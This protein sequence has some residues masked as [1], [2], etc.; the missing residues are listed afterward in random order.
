MWP[1]SD[2]LGFNGGRK[3]KRVK[4]K[5]EFFSETNFRALFN[6]WMKVLLSFF[7]RRVRIFQLKKEAA[8][9]LFAFSPVTTHTHKK[10]PLTVLLFLVSMV[11]QEYISVKEKTRRRWTRIAVDR[12]IR[13]RGV[14]WGLKMVR[15]LV[16][17]HS[18][19]LPSK[20]LSCYHPVWSS[21]T[22]RK[23]VAA[24]AAVISS[25]C[26]SWRETVGSCWETDG[27]AVREEKNGSQ[28]G[29]RGRTK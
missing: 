15:S 4:K 23:R 2:T 28:K 27:R 8:L 12:E 13:P 11:S 22:Q 6:Q 1:S 10:L 17:L 3:E 19:R 26:G 29:L 7:A 9:L 14:E 24:A 21:T 16:F 20:V 25:S 18:K 5:I